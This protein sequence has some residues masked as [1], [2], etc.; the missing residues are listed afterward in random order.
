MLRAAAA[1]DA[2]S[3]GLPVGVQVVAGPGRDE[4]TV[5]HVMRLIEQGA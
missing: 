3:R 2:D 5:L 1:T 4:S